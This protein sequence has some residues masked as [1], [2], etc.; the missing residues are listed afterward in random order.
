MLEAGR[1]REI[2][3]IDLSLEKSDLEQPADLSFLSCGSC[4][5]AAKAG[6]K[7]TILQDKGVDAI[8]P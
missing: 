1:P 2:V 7:N 6:V 8:A 5:Q 4:T 3:G